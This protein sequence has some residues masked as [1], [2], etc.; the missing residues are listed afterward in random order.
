MDKKKNLYFYITY[1]YIAEGIFQNPLRKINEMCHSKI[2]MV[3]F[4]FYI[5]YDDLELHCFKTFR[6]IFLVYIIENIKIKIRKFMYSIIFHIYFAIHNGT[7]I[8]SSHDAFYIYHLILPIILFI[9]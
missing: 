1:F 3:N 2:T 6:F 8:L 9:C 7:K 4:L 5:S